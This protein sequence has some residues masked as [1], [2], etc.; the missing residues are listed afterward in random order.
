MLLQ[1]V[2]VT[3]KA[4]LEKGRNVQRWMCRLSVLSEKFVF[5][6]TGLVELA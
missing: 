2:L 4:A 3:G 1:E 6:N 5:S